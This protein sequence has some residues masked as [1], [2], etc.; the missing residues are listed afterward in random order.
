[1][2]YDPNTHFLVHNVT[3][4]LPT[5]V[6]IVD[7]NKPF[8]KKRDDIPE[9]D[10]WLDPRQYDQYVSDRDSGLYKVVKKVTKPPVYQLPLN[11]FAD[12]RSKALQDAYDSSLSSRITLPDSTSLEDSIR[13][14]RR[15]VSEYVQCND[16]DMFCTFTFD[17][18]RYDRFNDVEIKRLFT[19]W[20]NYQQKQHIVKFKY[21]VVPEYHKKCQEC[22]DNHVTSC[23]HTD[24][25]KALHFHALLSGYK[26]SYTTA[27]NKK[28]N[29]QILKNKRPVYNFKE[30]NLGFS[31]FS[32]IQS[33]IGASRYI[34]KYIE[35]DM[36]IVV[37]KKRYWVS[38]GLNKP[39]V[40]YNSEYSSDPRSVV[41]FVAENYKISYIDLL[42]HDLN[43]AT[44]DLVLTNQ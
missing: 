1:M 10:F 9:S 30:Y 24:R 41:V 34:A 38:R 36:A 42:T 32:F 12:P 14:T 25:P 23:L 19:Q 4:V 27:F 29:K 37:G 7:F 18:A 44:L 2:N 39:L 13:R 20:L 22:V 16:F 33:K 40:I 43:N 8:L 26:G 6:K 35:K 15:L 11:G 21:L 5:T 31:N 28:T 3:K 17:P